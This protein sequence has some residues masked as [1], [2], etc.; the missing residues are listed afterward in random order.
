[1]SY[2]ILNTREQLTVITTVEYTLDDNSVITID[3]SHFMPKDNNDIINGIENR[4][5]TENNKLNIIEE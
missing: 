1:M 2:K 5:V 3:V 4:L